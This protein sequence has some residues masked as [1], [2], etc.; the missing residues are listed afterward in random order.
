M[1]NLNIVL[2]TKLCAIVLSLFGQDPY[3]GYE[4]DAE[5]STPADT[6]GYGSVLK[7]HTMEEP[8]ECRFCE[9]RACGMC[10]DLSHDHLDRLRKMTRTRDYQPGDLL[11]SDDEPIESY[12]TIKR[13]IVKLSKILP[14]GRQQTIGLGFPPDFI[15]RTYKDRNTYFVNA[16]TDV[17]V[18]TFPRDSFNKF[19]KATPSLEHRLFELTLNELDHARDWM[20]MLGQMSAIEKV[21]TLLLS[22]SE[23]IHR[24]QLLQG[25]SSEEDQF[26]L[27]LTRSEMAD[28]LGLTIETVSRQFSILKKRGLIDISRKRFITILDRATLKAISEQESL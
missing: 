6:S 13:G 27:P 4:R 21:S 5:M 15:G 24:A 7:T 23:K 19:L 2:Y 1:D 14:D 22:F 17:T 8:H 16:V 28:F 25:I 10:S 26:E 3:T 12:A 18:C 20:L 9:A 11:F